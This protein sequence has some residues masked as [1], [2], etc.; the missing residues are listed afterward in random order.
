MG[1]A[2]IVEGVEDA[3]Q[4]Q[5]IEARG[6][7]HFQSFFAGHPSAST[8][9][10]SSPALAGRAGSGD[11]AGAASVVIAAGREVTCGA[12]EGGGGAADEAAELSDSSPE[13]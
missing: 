3:R 9:A 13:S 12:A 8:C 7:S 4:R 2:C 6:G 10:S 11:G 5:L 1:L